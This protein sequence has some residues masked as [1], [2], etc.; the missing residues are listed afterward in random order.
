MTKLK[1][2]ELRKMD[3]KE[4]NS[5]VRELRSELLRLRTASAR[6]T[7]RKESGKIRSVRRNLARVLTII[8]EKELAAKRGVSG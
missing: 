4:L 6:G 5:K 2:A 1:P 7:L 3:I 8:R